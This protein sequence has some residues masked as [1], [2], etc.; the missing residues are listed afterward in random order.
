MSDIKNLRIIL[1]INKMSTPLI[2]TPL[3]PK[4]TAIWLLENT[5]L[6][7]EQISEFCGLHLLEIQGMADGEVSKGIVGIDPIAN[8]QLTREE[9]SRCEE[10]KNTKLSLA[11]SAQRF[12]RDQIK[13][14]KGAKYTPIARRQDKPDAVLWILRHCPEMNEAQITKLLG[15]TKVTIASVKEKTHWNYQNL[16][17][18]DPV[19]MGLCTQTEFDRVYAIAKGKAQAIAAK[20][21]PEQG[22]N[23][24]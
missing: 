12:M 20:A 7:F 24:F 6:T 8:H 22:I 2:N 14:K 13:Q 1:G 18:R 4:A 17:P 5:S 3:M 16:K 23:I 19:L 11:E 15:T 21:A 9:I 10:N